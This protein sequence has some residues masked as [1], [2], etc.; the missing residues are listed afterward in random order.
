[1]GSLRHFA[2]ACSSQVAHLLSLGGA[3]VLMAANEVP[4]LEEDQPCRCRLDALT[5][6]DSEAEVRLGESPF[7]RDAGRVSPRGEVRVAVRKRVPPRRGPLRVSGS[8]VRGGARIP[9]GSA[10]LPTPEASRIRGL[11]ACDRDRC[12]GE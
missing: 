9:P 10:M 11:P 8:G 1:M 4:A 3:V 7:P 2:A 5:L 6:C 12:Y